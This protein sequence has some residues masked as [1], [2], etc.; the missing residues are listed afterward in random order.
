MSTTCS[1]NRW[2]EKLDGNILPDIAET[3]ELN[4]MMMDGFLPLEL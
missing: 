3:H 2:E 4:G 1:N